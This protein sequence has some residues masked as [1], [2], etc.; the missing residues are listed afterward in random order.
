[1]P[2]RKPLVVVYICLF[3]LLNWLFQNFITL[4]DINDKRY[5]LHTITEIHVVS[6]NNFTAKKAIE[7]AYARIKEVEKTLNYF[8]IA[9]QI[10]LLNNRA[11][12]EAVTV[13]NDV[14][15]VLDAALEGSKKT[16]GAFDIT[17]TPITRLY[18]FGTDEKRVPAK[19]EITSKLAAVG[20]QYI[21]INHEQK[22]VRFLKRGLM[23]DLGGIL[24][25]YAVDQAVAVLKKHGIKH[26]LV[27]AGGNIYAIGNHRGKPWR[28]AIRDPRDL[29]HNI[30]IVIELENNACAT[31]GDY[32]QYFYENKKR[33]SHI[34]NPKTGLPSNLENGV[35]AVT[36]LADTATEAD[37]LST[38]CFVLGKEKSDKIIPNKT[39]FFLVTG[40]NN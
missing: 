27:N 24:K 21:Q 11:Y 5:A 13:N 30:P 6:R 20:Y 37:I 4:K 25:G 36:V 17:T 32:E 33:I 34:F 28:V 7:E 29:E 31:S 23:I 3:L 18:G 14:L 8:D 35:M 9:S 16:A 38:G 10:S 19:T 15:A 12:Y 22:T 26:A 39:F 2:V 1:M 40:N